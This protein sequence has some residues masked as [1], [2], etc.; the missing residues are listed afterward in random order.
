MFKVQ[1]DIRD[2][3]GAT[4]FHWETTFDNDVTRPALV[5]AMQEQIAKAQRGAARVI[6]GARIGRIKPTNLVTFSV[7]EF[8]GYWQDIE[9]QEQLSQLGNMRL[10]SKSG[11]EWK[12]N[13]FYDAIDFVLITM[14]Y[15]A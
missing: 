12:Y 5:D 1:I 9:V 8:D 3:K 4:N 15:E 2:N 6:A 13:D 10:C 14:G 11:G 7:Q